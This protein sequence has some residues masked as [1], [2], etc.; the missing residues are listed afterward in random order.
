MAD[1]LIV[2]VWTIASYLLGTVSFGDLVARVAGVDIRSQGTRN[3]GAANIYREIGPKYG[4]AV[5]ALDV[6]KGAVATAPLLLIDSLEWA[7]LPA[8]LAVVLGHIFPVFEKKSGGTGM[9][10][11]IGTTAGLAPF[12][13]LA[14]VPAALVILAITRNAGLTGCVLF[15]VTALLAGLVAQNVVEVLGVLGIGAVVLG[16]ARIQYGGFARPGSQ[17]SE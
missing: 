1:I 17:G 15:L 5:F 4:I 16:K 8:A 10:T 12:G 11:A 3:P 7:S 13:L 2:I 9:A 6:A 14:G